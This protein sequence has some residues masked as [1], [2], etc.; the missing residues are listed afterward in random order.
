MWTK[1]QHRQYQ[2]KHYRDN[3]EKISLYHK[4]RYKKHKEK[5]LKSC[6]KYQKNNSEKIRIYRIKRFK[7]KPWLKTKYNISNRCRNC[8]DYNGERRLVKNLITTEEL[9]TLW[10]RDKAYLMAK[11]SIDRIREGGNYTFKNC[12]FMELSMNQRRHKHIYGRYKGM[13]LN[14]K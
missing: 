11:P 7:E 2:Y 3:L 1:E 14:S 5:I 6:K 4:N 10:F 8:P 12:R 13:H 9:K